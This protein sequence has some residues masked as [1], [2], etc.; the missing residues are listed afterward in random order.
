MEENQHG[1]FFGVSLSPAVDGDIKASLLSPEDAR[2]VAA[3]EL[4][5]SVSGGQV[6]A[7]GPVNQE[8]SNASADTPF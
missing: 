4:M 8:T 1:K 5:K 3:H 2:F 7:T 6:R